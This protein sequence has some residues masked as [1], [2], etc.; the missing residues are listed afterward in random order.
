[1]AVLGLKILQVR[2]S[3][4]SGV[5]RT[6]LIGFVPRESALRHAAARILA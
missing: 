6:K 1:L 5:C 4:I 3:A 2:N